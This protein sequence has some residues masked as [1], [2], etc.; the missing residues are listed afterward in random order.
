MKG[1]R[2]VDFETAE[3]IREDWQSPHL[4]VDQVGAKHGVSGRNVRNIA[5]LRNWGERPKAPA[6]AA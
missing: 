1:K 2:V 3:A 6:K 5:K 4:T